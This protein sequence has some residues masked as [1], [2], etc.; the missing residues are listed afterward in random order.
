MRTSVLNR[1]GLENFDHHFGP[2]YGDITETI[3]LARERHGDKPAFLKVL[4]AQRK[5][6]FARLVEYRATNPMCKDLGDFM[7]GAGLFDC[8][9]GRITGVG[10]DKASR[11]I[12]AARRAGFTLTEIGA[13]YK[14]VSLVAT[15]VGAVFGGSLLASLGLYRAL[16]LFGV[17]QAVS[18]LG[19]MWLALSGKEHGADGQRVGV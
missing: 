1:E 13:V 12:T 18:N 6:Y 5:H 8:F 11:L 7:K 16:L 4:A 19:F 14:T 2:R 9:L 3:L 10:P 15:L 17:L